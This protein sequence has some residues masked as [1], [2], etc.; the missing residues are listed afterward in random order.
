MFRENVLVNE[1]VIRRIAGTLV[2]L[3]VDYEKFQ[4]RKSKESRLLRPY[5]RKRGD[6]QGVWILSPDGEV[7]A[8][9]LSGFGD[10]VRK[11]LRLVDEALEKHGP[12]TPAKRSV[13]DTQPFRGKGVRPDGSV[14]LAEYVRRRDRDKIRTPVIS[15]VDLTPPEFAAFAPLAKTGEDIAAGDSWEVPASVAKRL[16]RIASPMCY[17]HAPQPDWVTEIRLRATVARVSG[18]IAEIRYEGALASERVIRRGKILSEQRLALEGRGVYDISTT[19][20]TSLRL[21]GSGRFR[22]PEEAPDRIVPFD[23]LVE[24]EVGPAHK[25]DPRADR[26]E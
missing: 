21:L 13:V 24:W 2:P 3:A 10:M 20:L 7:L 6:K 14:T 23:A 16:C 5:I 11:T 9:P 4:R 22:W 19:K 12:V 8:G 17:Q 15:S 18:S 25:L 1:K 26:L